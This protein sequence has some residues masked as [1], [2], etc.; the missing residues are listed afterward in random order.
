VTCVYP[1]RIVIKDERSNKEKHREKGKR[2]HT[3]AVLE[4]SI[5]LVL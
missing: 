4:Y 1:G 3:I 2:K 5:V